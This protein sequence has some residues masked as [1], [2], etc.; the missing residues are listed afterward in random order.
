MKTEYEFRILDV[1][2][3]DACKRLNVLG[4][5]YVGNWKQ[6]RFI[7]DSIP[8]KDHQIIRLRTNG[9]EATLTYKVFESTAIDGAK[10]IEVKVSSFEKT[11]EILELMGHKARSTQENYRIRFMYN[12]A[13]IDI[14]TWPLIGT[15]VEV[16]GR[17]EK[18]VMDVIKSLGFNDKEVTGD[19]A[20]ELYQ[21]LGMEE[22]D[23]SILAFTNEEKEN[24]KKQEERL[25]N[26]QII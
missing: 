12:D 19:A 11:N 26:E 20:F 16:E 22:K 4:A 17:D 7:Y 2:L 23:I 6:R 24:Y 15:Y 21:R 3:Y 5:V 25:K 18:H 9:E 10:E 1:S 14:D 13:E 8:K